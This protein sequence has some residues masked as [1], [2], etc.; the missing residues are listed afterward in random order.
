MQSIQIMYDDAADLSAFTVRQGRGFKR[1]PFFNG[2]IESSCFNLSSTVVARGVFLPAI[3]I[4]F[5]KGVF[6]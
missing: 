3:S 2:C 5:S 6:L 4:V 1:L